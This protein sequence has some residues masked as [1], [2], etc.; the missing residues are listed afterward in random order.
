MPGSKRPFHHYLKK[1][2]MMRPLLLFFLLLPELFAA[3]Q[4]IRFDIHSLPPGRTPGSTIYLAGSFN[5]W[6]PDDEQ[7]RFRDNGT[8]SYT[9]TRQLP[10]GTYEYKLT[11]GSWDKVE[12]RR[13]GSGI[14]NRS[15]TVE[16]DSRVELTV[17]GWQDAFT[18]LPVHTAGNRV[19]IMDTAF[20]IG[21]LKRTRRIWIYLPEGYDASSTR[22]PV[23]YLQDGQ[24]LFD[25]ATAYAG[26]WGV[27]ECLD[28]LSR[29]CIVVG[30]D[31]GGE[32]RMTEYSP[33][34]FSFRWFHPAAPDSLYKAEG[35]QYV[36]FLV[37]T[38]KPYID[39][40]YRTQ[41]GRSSTFIGGS[42]MGGLISFYALLRYPKVFG[43]AGVFSPSFWIAPSLLK[44]VKARGKKVKARIFFYA[45]KQESE[46][47]VPDVLKV[48]EAMQRV[49]ASVMTTVIRDEG[50]HNE[51]AWRKEFPVF[52]EWL[53]K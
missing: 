46:Q 53:R 16:G 1:S 27:D 25:A 6:K 24:N 50:K 36:D 33:W 52:Y 31:N 17:E 10:P 3:A 18:K 11:R 9:L 26:E 45:G 15:L 42:S 38:L 28:T 22:Y 35:P 30:I 34:D 21:Q 23:L 14:P 51:A 4:Q 47:M 20:R 40:N 12:C 13:D 2:V 37:K 19:R 44:E 49:S 8:G 29:A 7:Y 39:R 43:G 41:R 5:G 32:K 48:F